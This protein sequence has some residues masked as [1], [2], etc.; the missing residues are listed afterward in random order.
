MTPLCRLAHT[1]SLYVVVLLCQD[2]ETLLMAR[3]SRAQCMLQT[4][5]AS[6]F[7]NRFVLLERII[8]ALSCQV[9]APD[10]QGNRI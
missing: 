8:E 1:T 7:A 9:F 2:E 6:R 3:D 4:A 5:H 10:I